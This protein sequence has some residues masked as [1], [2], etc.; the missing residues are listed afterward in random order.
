MPANNEKKKATVVAYSFLGPTGK[1][2]V[3]AER[4]Q[5]K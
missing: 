1:Y 5:Q 4:A 2:N 3:R